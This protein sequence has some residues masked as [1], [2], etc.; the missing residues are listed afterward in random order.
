MKTIKLNLVTREIPNSET[1]IVPF[2]LVFGKPIVKHCRISKKTRKLFNE[3]IAKQIA[4]LPPQS[5]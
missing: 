3:Y 1:V 5:S 4:T 2:N